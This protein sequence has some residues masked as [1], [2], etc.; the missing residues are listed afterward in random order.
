MLGRQAR[1]R[2][3]GDRVSRKPLVALAISLALAPLL[4]VALNALFIR[5]DGYFARR[6]IFAALMDERFRSIDARLCYPAAARHRPRG[7]PGRLPGTE[8]KLLSMQALGRLERAGDPHGVAVANLLA[9]ELSQARARLD[10]LIAEGTRA[11]AVLNDRAVVALTEGDIAGA[12]ELLDEILSRDD[13]HPQALFNRAQALQALQLPRSAQTLFEQVGDLKESGWG[14]EARQQAE[15][16]RAEARRKA[17]AWKENRRLRDEMARTGKPP[18]VRLVEEHPESLHEGFFDALWIAQDA[19]AVNALMPLARALDAHFGSS[20]LTRL[21]AKVSNTNFE[22]RRPLAVRYAGYIEGKV[23]G[24]EMVAFALEH[25]E[26]PEVQDLVLGAL[27]VTG[28]V[29]DHLELFRR[30]AAPLDD[31]WLETVEQE[32]RWAHA[33]AIRN[34]QEAARVAADGLARCQRVP[35]HRRCV[36]YET[37]L[38]QALTRQFRLTEAHSHLR[39][40]RTSALARGLMLQDSMLLSVTAKLE[41]D[42]FRTSMARAFTEEVTRN[43]ESRCIDRMDAHERL[44]QDALWRGRLQEAAGHLRDVKPCPRRSTWTP[45][46]LTIAA[47][48]RRIDPALVDVRAAE[49]T[50][51]ALPSQLFSTAESQGQM[52]LAIGRWRILDPDPLPGR[53]QLQKALVA[54]ANANAVER[55]LVESGAREELAFDAAKRG[56]WSESLD[57]L[58]ASANVR[59]R[60][61]CTLAVAVETER[62]LVIARGP[63]ASATTKGSGSAIEGSILHRAVPNGMDFA[64]ATSR[65]PRLP[66]RVLELLRGC[67]SVQ[68]V[69]P[70]RQRRWPGVLPQDTAWSYANGTLDGETPSDIRNDQPKV[71]LVVS[72][73][74]PP[75]AM[76]L[77]RLTPIEPDRSPGAISLYGADASP[78]NVLRR[79]PEADIVEF[80]VHGV[81][82]TEVS[83]ETSLILSPDAN[84]DFLL[85]RT[86]LEGL[87][88]PRRPIVLLAACHAAGVATRR[89]DAGELAGAFM[90]AGARA[91]V[92]ST[93]AIPDGQGERFFAQLRLELERERSVARALRNVRSKLP[94]GKHSAW[95][96]AMLAYE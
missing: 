56:H 28:L 60:E 21:V 23:R 44:A 82:D 93:S 10:V 69:A 74:R 86:D 33:Y 19:A 94:R 57:W 54:A 67:D 68:V 71:R 40:A 31:P 52:M 90:R 92:A 13:R 27:A 88:L 32:G 14:E 18:D 66:N 78:A 3:R 46:G 84:G 43:P 16:L 42:R 59:P 5:V 30:L 2:G 15:L 26:E 1:S 50:I 72:D 7:T 87:A 24:D 17:S 48:L 45:L 85:S 38:A 80:H 51:D 4:A 34:Y 53:E 49:K 61:R 81:T 39:H 6:S 36:M 20:S 76:L 96:E 77:S 9:G 37:R 65:P 29:K 62:E 64:T 55:P 83:Q 47:S 22:K 11:P 25:K 89:P 35:L 58:I 79:L 8:G 75:I 73:P 41:V 91:V 12:L 95:V 70:A 63:R